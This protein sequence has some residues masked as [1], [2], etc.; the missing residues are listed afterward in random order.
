[1]TCNN[2]AQPSLVCLC[3]I[4]SIT[5]SMASSLN[6]SA[7]DKTM[8]EL[9]PLP[10]MAT[11]NPANQTD[12]SY[13]VSVQLGGGHYCS[14]ALVRPDWVLTSAHCVQNTRANYKVLLGNNLQNKNASYRVVK[15]IV[16]HQDF[17]YRTLANNIALLQLAAPAASRF[18]PLQLPTAAVMAQ[19]VYPGSYLT[20]ASWGAFKADGSGPDQLQQVDLPLVANNEC[21]Q[22]YLYQAA[23]FASMICAGFAKGTEHHCVA[24][25]GAPLVARYQGVDYSLG[26]ASWGQSCQSEPIPAES[27]MLFSSSWFY[28]DWINSQLPPL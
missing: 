7:A 1:M 16:L 6:C 5:A 24:D 22:Q 10:L 2:K 26:L 14:G 8:A 9:Y 19:L 21:E 23:L 18:R 20:T 27:Y 15:K 12:L 13:Q 4:L 11:G 28:L 17:N 3:L 25:S